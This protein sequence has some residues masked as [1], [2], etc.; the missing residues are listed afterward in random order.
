MSKKR[1]TRAPYE[2]H[3]LEGMVKKRYPHAHS[4]GNFKELKCYDMFFFGEGVRV[5]GLGSFMIRHRRTLS[6][7]PLDSSLKALKKIQE[8]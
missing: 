7:S 4:L 3:T 2:I 1:H 8:L 6:G 5:G